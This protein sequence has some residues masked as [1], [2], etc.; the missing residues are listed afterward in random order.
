MSLRHVAAVAVV[1]AGVEL[2]IELV[3]V[4]RHGH[5]RG[6]GRRR[7][8]RPTGEVEHGLPR[9]ELIELVWWWWRWV[10]HGRWVGQTRWVEGWRP[11]SLWRPLTS[12]DGV[13]ET[14]PHV[15]ER[16]NL[17]GRQGWLLAHSRSWEEGH[18]GAHA[19]LSTLHLLTAWRLRYKSRHGAISNKR[20]REIT[21]IRSRWLASPG[22]HAASLALSWVY[23]FNKYS[24]VYPYR[25]MNTTVWQ[26]EVRR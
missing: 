10:G 3:I 4:L 2:S 14:F 19:R 15:R 5:A 7:S 26:Y 17:R 9:F 6:R 12:P 16:R 8:T 13:R 23:C 20:S 11:L 21:L 24:H 18:H 25:C 22:P 1:T